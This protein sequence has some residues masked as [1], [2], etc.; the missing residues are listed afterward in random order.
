MSNFKNSNH[1]VDQSVYMLT[2][3]EVKRVRHLLN[4]ISKPP[5]RKDKIMTFNKQQRH[6]R[7][8][9]LAR[10]VCQ[11]H[12]IAEQD[13][14]SYC[15]KKYLVMARADF[16]KIAYNHIGVTKT[17]IGMF[18][19]RTKLGSHSSIINLLFKPESHVYKDLELIYKNTPKT[20]LI[21]VEKMVMDV[22]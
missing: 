8:K 12:C 16:A 1:L 11:S 2:P 17:T 9:L 19:G 5:V 21:G 3:E 7:M 22:K 14:F 18:M 20:M 6:D 15:R 10:L 4:L 13:F